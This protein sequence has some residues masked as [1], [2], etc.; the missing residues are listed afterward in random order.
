MT[1]VFKKNSMKKKFSPEFE[2]FNKDNEDEQKEI[3]QHPN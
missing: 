2:Q 3:V 1:L